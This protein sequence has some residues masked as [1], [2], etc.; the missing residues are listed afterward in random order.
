MECVPGR[1]P[2]MHCGTLPRY[3]QPPTTHRFN[4]FSIINQFIHYSQSYNGFMG[5]VV[6]LVT[7]L[8][9]TFGDQY[10]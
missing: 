2:W 1:N 9:P 6:N 7:I 5:N 3:A 10:N 8:T 4:E